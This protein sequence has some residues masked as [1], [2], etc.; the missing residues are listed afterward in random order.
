MTGGASPTKRHC[1][2]A[3]ANAVRSRGLP[4]NQLTN[5]RS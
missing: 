3:Q 2:R 5:V 1:G 4:P